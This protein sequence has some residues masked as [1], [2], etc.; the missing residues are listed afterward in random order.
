[1]KPM[2]FSF[3]AQAGF[4]ETKD[5]QGAPHHFPLMR[6]SVAITS[7]DHRQFR[8]YAEL[9]ETVTSLKSYAK[10]QKDRDKSLVIADRRET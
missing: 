2:E 1:M 8:H 3:H 9:I 4:V 6:L 5:R 10:S 7:N